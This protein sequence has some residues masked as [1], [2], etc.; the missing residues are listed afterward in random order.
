MYYP[1]IGLEIHAELKTKT[2]MFCGSLNDP[3]E[4]HP[5]V[6][7][8]PVCMGHPGTLPTINKKAVES[9]IKV[10]LALGAKIAEISKFDRKNY[11]YPD[12]PKGYQISQYDQPLCF[13]GSLEISGNKIRIRRVHLEE[14]TGRLAHIGKESLVDFNRAGMPLMELVTEPDIKNGKEAKEFSKELQLILR[15][16]G[17]SSADME[18]GEMRCEANISISK[19]KN[20]LGT[21]VEVKNLNSFKAVEKAIE[22]EIDRQTEMLEDGKKIIQETRGWDDSSQKTFSQREKEEAHDYRYFPE[23]DLPQL[24]TKSFDLEKIKAEISELPQN[25]RRRFK[26]EYDLNDAQIET[27][28]SEKGLGDYFERTI[29]EMK[30]WDADRHKQRL[31][32]EHFPKIIQLSA[33][34]LISDLLSLINESGEK[35]SSLLITPENYA[36]FIV[37]IHQGDISS[38][39]AKIILKEM[40]GTGSD[41]SHIMEEKGLSQMSDTEELE[42]VVKEVIVNNPKAVNDYKSGQK[43]VIQFLAGQIMAKTK[44]RANPQIVQEFLSKLLDNNQ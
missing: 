10:G 17:V 8:C 27:L 21:K 20:T 15:Y 9:V 40:Y 33:N 31:L 37:M 23:P 22:Y 29:S 2:K 5:N 32:P 30:E 11:F 18:K 24:E 43:N 4:R 3:D 35:F 34:Y 28:V 42:N 38:K 41:P 1:T 19:D 44:G 14:D 39:A 16:L 36:E 26:A 12:L 13:D 6:N 25:R 7:I